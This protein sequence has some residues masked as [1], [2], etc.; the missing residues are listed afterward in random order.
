[1]TNRAEIAARLSTRHRE[2]FK[3]FSKG[4]SDALLQS[5]LT[6]QQLKV[7]TLLTIDGPMGGN[8]VAR[9]LGISMATVTGIVDRLVER[10]LV[11]RSE[12]PNDRRVR[13]IALTEVGAEQMEKSQAQEMAFLTSIFDQLTEEQLESMNTVMDGLLVVAR[14]MQEEE[15]E[16][17]SQEQ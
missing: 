6:M 11:E 2:F 12:D 10:G 15:E 9:A 14:R 17:P 4:R 16:P 1:M 3:L 13:M 5:T 8:E 7:M